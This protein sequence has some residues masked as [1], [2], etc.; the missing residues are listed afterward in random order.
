MTIFEKY[1]NLNP[2]M[3]L[4]V[5]RNGY[6]DIDGDRCVTN[7]F[8][9]VFVLNKR[10][11]IKKV[12]REGSNN[13]VKK[14]MLSGSYIAK[15]EYKR[16]KEI[17]GNRITLKDVTKITKGK[18]REFMVINGERYNKEMVNYMMRL[19]G[20]KTCMYKSVK[21]TEK[22]HPILFLFSS[23]MGSCENKLIG[24]ILPTR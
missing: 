16:D 23:E 4:V 7:D 3:A 14:C 21:N 12:D 1:S 8:S 5:Y 19:A 20:L 2:S 11:K 9:F 17:E 15:E 10:V 13:M 6:F 24:G 22:S 18:T